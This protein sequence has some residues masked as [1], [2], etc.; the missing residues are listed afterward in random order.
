MHRCHAPTDYVMVASFLRSH[1]CR[2]QS[3]ATSRNLR[4]A[5][6]GNL[7][8]QLLKI[9]VLPNRQDNPIT[10]R[11]SFGAATRLTFGHATRTHYLV[12][13]LRQRNP[14]SSL[15]SFTLIYWI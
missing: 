15:A 14:T 13:G 2:R 5:K 9:F 8:V 1:W 3:L 12:V 6:I 11:C 4:W 10:K 7:S